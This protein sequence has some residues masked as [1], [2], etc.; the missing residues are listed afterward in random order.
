MVNPILAAVVSF[1]IPGIGQIIAGKTKR[2]LVF[3]AAEIIM[4]VLLFIVGDIAIFLSLIL[5]I[6]AAYDAYQIASV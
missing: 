1:I 4:F 5:S 6:Y 2:G 3:L